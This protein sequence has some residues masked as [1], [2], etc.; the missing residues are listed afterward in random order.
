MLFFLRIK[1]FRQVDWNFDVLPHL[2]QL[3]RLWLRTGYPGLLDRRLAWPVIQ[4][5]S[6]SQAQI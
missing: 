5:H 3:V 6:E 1:D 2:S 4:I